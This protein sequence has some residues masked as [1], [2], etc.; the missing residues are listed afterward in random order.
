VQTAR[1]LYVHL[2]YKV[3]GWPGK[4]PAA[5]AIG[6][7]ADAAYDADIAALSAYQLPTVIGTVNNVK[8]KLLIDSGA[9]LSIIDYKLVYNLKIKNSENICISAASGH[10]ID[11]VGFCT[12]NIQLSDLSFQHKFAVVKNFKHGLLIGSDFLSKH[13]AIINYNNNT[14][15]LKNLLGETEAIEFKGHN[16]WENV[17][18]NIE[19]FSND[20]N[21]SVKLLCARDVKI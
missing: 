19:A 16:D 9:G 18:N 10:K 14:L 7:G 20:D 13:N 11:C 1:S 12:V 17:F 21:K 2:C 15:E 6:V 4:L 8:T 5:E 3:K